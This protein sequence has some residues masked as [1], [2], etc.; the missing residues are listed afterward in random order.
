[1]HGLSVPVGKLGYQLSLP[2]T[3]SSAAISRSET[4]PTVPEAQVGA[5]IQRPLGSQRDL[6]RLERPKGEVPPRVKFPI[7]ASIIRTSPGHD[8]NETAEGNEAE[9]ESA[10]F[11]RISTAV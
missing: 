4:E 11:S 7:G 9:I 1:M 3:L 5:Q 6:T 8:L 2:R 10:E